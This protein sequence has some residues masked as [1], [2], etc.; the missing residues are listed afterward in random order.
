MATLRNTPLNQL[1][2]TDAINT[3]EAI[4]DQSHEPFTAPP[5]LLGIPR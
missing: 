4:R 5:D 2:A 1:R 3:T